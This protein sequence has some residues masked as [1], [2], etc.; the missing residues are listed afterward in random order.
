M[1]IADMLKEIDGLKSL[2]TALQREPA[3]LNEEIFQKYVEFQSTP[4]V[5]KYVRDKG[6]R[7]ESNGNFQ[8]SDVCDIIR[9]GYE[10]IEPVLVQKADE[11]F[12]KN[13]KAVSGLW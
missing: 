7:T 4:K 5:G 1:Q 3:S 10:G 11:I 12:K 13:T 8:P 9:N 6:I 2:I